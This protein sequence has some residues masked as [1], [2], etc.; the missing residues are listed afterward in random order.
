MKR[1]FNFYRTIVSVAREE[2][3]FYLF[4]FRVLFFPVC[5]LG[6]RRAYFAQLVEMSSYENASLYKPSTTYIQEAVAFSR[7]RG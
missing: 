4:F 5:L 2:C 7:V 3:Y 1:A 6:S